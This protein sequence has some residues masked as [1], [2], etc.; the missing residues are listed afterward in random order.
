MNTYPLKRFIKSACILS[1]FGLAHNA[2]ADEK[3][4][5]QI[6]LNK[7]QQ[8]VQGSLES[9]ETKHKEF[10]ALLKEIDAKKDLEKLFQKADEV[11]QSAKTGDQN[12]AQTQSQDLPALRKE[13]R[14]SMKREDIDKIRNNLL[15]W[16]LAI[17][18]TLKS[19]ETWM[20]LKKRADKAGVKTTS[21]FTENYEKVRDQYRLV[22]GRIAEVDS[23]LK[24]Q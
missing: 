10:V 17:E 13:L 22:E 15:N 24:N 18:A 21:F 9:L 8:H 5:V 1:L 16:K 7:H 20:A 2:L 6:E 4:D 14:T 11:Y 19:E 3:E 12:R 23:T